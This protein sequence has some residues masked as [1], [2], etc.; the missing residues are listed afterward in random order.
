M[1]KFWLGIVFMLVS[2]FITYASLTGAHDPDLVGIATVI[3]AMAGGV[4]G[5]V[6]GNVREHASK[7]NDQK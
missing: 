6:W 5:V 2:G 3:G 7:A 4:F 1:R